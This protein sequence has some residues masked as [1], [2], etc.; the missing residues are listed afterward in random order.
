MEQLHWFFL[1]YLPFLFTV[2]RRQL[3]DILGHMPPRLPTI[4]V[5]IHVGVNL[6]ANYPGIV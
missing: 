1:T 2:Q 3:W 6:T 5:L 4:S